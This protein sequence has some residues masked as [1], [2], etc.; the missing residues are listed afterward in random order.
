MK[1]VKLFFR[2]L[3][4]ICLLPI[5]RLANGMIAAL[6]G[7]TVLKQAIRTTSEG[8]QTAVVVYSKPDQDQEVVLVGMIHVA[9]E[10]FF[11]TVLTMLDA[12]ESLGGAVVYEGVGRPTPEQMAG[13]TQEEAAVFRMFE[14]MFN[15]QR[16]MA[17]SAGLVYQKDALPLKDSWINADVPLLE[18]VRQMLKRNL[19][20]YMFGMLHGTEVRL[21]VKDD[22]DP[23][24]EFVADVLFRNVHLM[25]LL[26]LPVFL[27][28]KVRNMK[29]LILDERNV[30]GFQGI[31]EAL[32]CH[33]QVISTWGAAHLS[34]I[35]KM[36]EQEGFAVTGTT[37]NTVYRYRNFGLADLREAM[38]RS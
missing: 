36:L 14:Q 28:P 33:D 4:A 16:A 11:R 37:W 29:R 20:K 7:G 32:K 1:K 26:Y 34:G 24:A 13:L 31:M 35:G 3:L 12:V 27:L 8:L 6:R 15:A 10:R 21:L 19:V 23:M 18:T 22:L 2:F 30:A 25:S 38:K 5:V 17:K 9:E